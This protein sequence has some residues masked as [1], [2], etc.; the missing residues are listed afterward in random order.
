MNDKVNPCEV[1]VEPVDIQSTANK[2]LKA[3]VKEAMEVAF[4][5]QLKA[6]EQMSTENE[7]KVSLKFY[8]KLQTSIDPVG[9]MAKCNARARY[10][11]KRIAVQP[12]ALGRRK[13]VT[14]SAAPQPKGAPKRKFKA[15][16]DGKAAKRG[17]KSLGRTF[18][19]RLLSQ[20]N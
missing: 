3:Q 14:G 2:A 4:T 1:E 12:T 6:I 18:N 17:R 16:T 5:R 20:I 13:N 15:E 7:L 9:F 8:S 19:D 10:V 11:G